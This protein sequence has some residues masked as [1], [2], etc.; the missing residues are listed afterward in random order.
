MNFLC[1]YWYIPL[2][3]SDFVN[4]LISFFYLVWIR[5]YLLCRFSGRT[6][7]LFLYIVLFLL[8]WFQ[9]PFWLFIAFYSSLCV[10]FFYGSFNCPV[11]LLVWNLWNLFMKT[12]SPIKF[13]LSTTFIGSN[14]F[15]YMYINLPSISDSLYFFISVLTQF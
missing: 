11:N 14:K 4:L 3:V 15:G 12:I 2:L 9:T 6:N 10:Y 13:P 8:D 5:I 1:V 7:F